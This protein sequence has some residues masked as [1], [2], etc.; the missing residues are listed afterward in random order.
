MTAIAGAIFVVLCVLGGFL[1]AGGNLHV[2]W[3]PAEF[4]VIGGAA[5]GAFVIQSPKKVL[6]HT[7]KDLTH[8]FKAKEATRQNYLELLLLLG[9]LFQIIRR[10]GVVAVEAHVANPGQSAIF[11]KYPTVLANPELTEFIA[12]NVKV[13]V[14]AKMQP[15]ELDAIME[16]DID[17][18]HHHAVV[19]SHGINKVAEAFPGLGIV[20]AVLGVV[21]TMGKLGAPPEELGHSI[22]AALIGTFLGVLLCY[23]FVG[24]L[25]THIQ[26]LADE[27][28]S[29]LTVARVAI[30]G[31]SQG[32]SPGGAVEAGRRAVAGHDRPSFDEL[33]A[34]M[35]GGGK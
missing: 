19:P 6:T 10:E 5:L 15:H 13:F 7:L 11:T 25:S 32:M 2:L 22:G 21:L 17:A 35:R 31:F 8:V 30:I 23:G 26:H 20:A 16:A 27:A 33:D 18:R 12:D 14:A 1:Y 3:Q 34:A 29:Q 9:A 4:I 28:K 24:P